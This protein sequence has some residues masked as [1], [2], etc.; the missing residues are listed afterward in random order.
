[1]L[2]WPTY[3]NL[4]ADDRN[5]FDMIRALPGGVPGLLALTNQL[6][7]AGVRVLWPYNPWDQGTRPEGV[8]DAQAMA[9]LQARWVLCPGPS[10]GAAGF[11]LTAPVCAVW[12]ALGSIN[13]DGFNGDTMR[14]IPEDFY[15]VRWAHAIGLTQPAPPLDLPPPHPPPHPP[16]PPLDT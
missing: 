8:S 7:Q 11:P 5:Q 2:I 12:M 10:T 6:H 1:M 15:Q 14:T 9:Q 3:T 4:G 16:P 13:G